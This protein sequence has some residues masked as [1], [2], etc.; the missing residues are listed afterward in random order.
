MEKILVV[1][2]SPLAEDSVSCRLADIFMKNYQAAHPEDQLKRIDLSRLELPEIDEELIAYFNGQSDGDNGVYTEIDD[3]CEEFMTADR[4]VFALPHWNLIVPP[5]M[6]SYSLAVMRAGK[7]FR[8]TEKGPVGMLENKKALI[9]LASGGT[10]NTDNPIMHCYGV[11]WLKGILGL[12]GIKD[13]SVLY[14]QGM[15]ECPDKTQEIVN[16]ACLEVEAF[17][18][19]W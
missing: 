6:V 11:D 14:A 3:L 19:E 13:V 16:N 17:S 4:T 18:K 9:L 12:C 8:Y 1:T 7:S 2:A 15:E 10:C 5:K